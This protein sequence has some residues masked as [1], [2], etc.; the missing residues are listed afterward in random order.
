MVLRTHRF[1]Y[2]TL[3]FALLVVLSNFL[4]YQPF[5]QQKVTGPLQAHVVWGS[6]LDLV[7]VLPLLLFA[8]FQM[9]WKHVLAASVLGLFGARLLVP[10]EF[11]ALLTPLLVAGIA[12]EGLFLVA[13]LLLIGWLVLKIPKIRHR[14]RQTTLSPVY[15]AVPAVVVETKDHILL[16]LFTME[17]LVFY[18][19]LFSYKQKAPSHKGTF[20][21]HK[22]SSA[23]ALHIMVIHALVIE[24]VAIHWFL[25]S[26]SPVLSIILLILNIY[27]LIY[28]LADI[29]ITRL[30]PLEV[31][32]D[33]LAVSQGLMKS[34]VIPIQDIQEVRSFAKSDQVDETIVYKDFEER[35]PNVVLIF[36]KPVAMNLAF[37]RRKDVL[38]LAIAVDEPHGF[39][40]YVS[41]KKSLKPL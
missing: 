38:S 18:Y 24:T 31:K 36:N 20:T 11:H 32:G 41:E 12:F 1:R 35:E 28:I 37:G 34:V 17:W 23:I 22:S 5:I 10:E 16:R 9:G 3:T 33:Q 25:H 15:S 40:K 29:Q 19:G 39:L 6:L 27:G 8:T 2:L 7:I 30:A 4:L 21:L 14:M 26:Y 13:E